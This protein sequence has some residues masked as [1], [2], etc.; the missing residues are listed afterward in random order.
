MQ[1]PVRSRYTLMAALVEIKLPGANDAPLSAAR[2]HR[3]VDCGSLGV[4]RAIL[5][6]FA[7]DGTAQA[8]RVAMRNRSGWQRLYRRA[9]PGAAQKGA[10]FTP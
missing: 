10:G 6:A 3:L 5:R 1:P 8:V 7:G 4:V 9:S 2:I